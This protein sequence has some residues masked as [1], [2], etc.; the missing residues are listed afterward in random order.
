MQNMSAHT[1]RETFIIKE[2]Y[3]C[4]ILVMAK[5]WNILILFL[6]PLEQICTPRYHAQRP[7][8]YNGLSREPP[9][10]NVTRF[11]CQVI[12]NVL[13]SLATSGHKK[14]SSLCLFSK[15]DLKSYST[16][17]PSD[18]WYLMSISRNF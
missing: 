11:I 4:R 15:P 3:I 1:S 18:Y 7:A 17:S 9:P 12:K 16:R 2:I 13:K 10:P 14:S 8:S 5:I 6:E